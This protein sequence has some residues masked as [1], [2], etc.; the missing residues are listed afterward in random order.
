MAS[1][2]P[3]SAPKLVNK[4]QQAAP[5]QGKKSGEAIEKRLTKG[6]NIMAK[7]N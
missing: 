4:A 5:V 3:E 7:A 6:E 2:K 1:A